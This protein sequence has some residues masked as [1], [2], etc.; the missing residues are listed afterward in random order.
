MN[1]VHFSFDGLLH[2]AEEGDVTLNWSPGDRSGLRQLSIAG[3]L[4][5]HN[6]KRRHGTAD[7]VL[8]GLTN[9]LT[10][11]DLKQLRRPALTLDASGFAFRIPSLLRDEARCG[12]TLIYGQFK[13]NPELR[14]AFSRFPYDKLPES[15]HAPA[16][17]AAA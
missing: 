1:S 7:L 13:G 12:Q 16:K 2:W 15:I 4:L 14:E 10:S 8:Q 6:A 9:L 5:L 3:R 11:Q 17:P